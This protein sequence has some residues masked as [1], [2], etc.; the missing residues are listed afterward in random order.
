MLQKDRNTAAAPQTKRGTVTLGQVP[1]NQDNPF[2]RLLARRRGLLLQRDLAPLAGIMKLGMVTVREW[3]LVLALVEG[4]HPADCDGRAAESSWTERQPRL[5]G[6]EMSP[7]DRENP[8]HGLLASR[9]S[10]SSSVAE[11]GHDAINRIWFN[12]LTAPQ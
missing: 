1:S 12:A 4:W 8:A 7:R 10:H 2:A 5:I 9:L 11:N 6:N 3:S